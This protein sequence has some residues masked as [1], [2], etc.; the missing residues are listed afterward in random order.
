MPLVK[1]MQEQQSIID[2]QN[3]KINTL[4]KQVESLL[5]DKQEIKELKTQL[6]ELSKKI[7]AST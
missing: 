1:G 5:K 7:N 2:W 3:Q 4:E 6:E